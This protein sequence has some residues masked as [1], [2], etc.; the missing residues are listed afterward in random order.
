MR[1]YESLSAVH[2]KNPLLCDGA[3]L[4]GFMCGNQYQPGCLTKD[5][6]VRLHSCESG[7]EC[8]GLKN[9]GSVIWITPVTTQA[10]QDT[11]IFDD[12]LDYYGESLFQDNQFNKLESFRT[13]SRLYSE[14]TPESNELSNISPLSLDSSS[15]PQNI[16]SSISYAHEDHSHSAPSK[17][18]MEYLMK[19]KR[20]YRS[21][22]LQMRLLQVSS[23]SCQKAK[24]KGYSQRSGSHSSDK[25][26]SYSQ[27]VL[28]RAID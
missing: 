20:Y 17:F 18:V 24:E 4:C 12:G 27:T 28:Q 23:N 19:S 14:S 21:L 5:S 11:D 16:I 15:F 26:V 3:A 13:L 6:R 22:M 7:A 8:A 1:L 9:S 25:I 2:E 10:D